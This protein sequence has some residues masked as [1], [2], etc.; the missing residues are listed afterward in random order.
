MAKEFIEFYCKNADSMKA[1]AAETGDFM[2]NKTVMSEATISNPLLNGQN[3]YETLVKVLGNLD[4]SNKLTK[5][6]S[7]I[8]NLFNT[9][10]QGY[11]DGTYSTKDEAIAAFKGEVAT[12]FPDI[13]VE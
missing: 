13:I 10:V 1:Y 6:D 11:L 3:H 8:K 9:S 2:N 4:L 7:V 12:S 5:Y